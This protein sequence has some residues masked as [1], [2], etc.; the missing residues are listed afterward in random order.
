MQRAV[1][2]GG[3]RRLAVLLQR[4]EHKV[5]QR[6]DGPRLDRRNRRTGGS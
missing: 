6:E 1:T 5:D 2:L 4:L 3:R